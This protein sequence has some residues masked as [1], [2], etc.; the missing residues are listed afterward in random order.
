MRV[1][2]VIEITYDYYSFEEFLGV[3]LTRRAALK[4]AKERDS[5]YP[6]VHDK[7]C[8]DNHIS[9]TREDL[10]TE[11]MPI[12]KNYMQDE[13]GNKI[14]VISKRNRYWYCRNVKTDKYF[15]INRNKLEEID[16]AES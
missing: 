4:I 8:D 10:N 2:T 7:R 5:L 6:I 14:E 16:K 9:I 12:K 11:V 3:A 15:K 13:K 1:F